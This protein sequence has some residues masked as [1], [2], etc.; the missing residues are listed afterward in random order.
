[1]RIINMA[2]VTALS[3]LSI[4]SCGSRTGKKSASE[5]AAETKAVE[6]TETCFTAIDKYLS[7]VIGSWPA[8]EIPKVNATMEN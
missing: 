1:M 7:D 3:I 8:V 5:P 4:A 2:L 6:E